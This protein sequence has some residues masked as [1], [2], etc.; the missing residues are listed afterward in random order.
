MGRAVEG[1]RG[2]RGGSVV[3]AG[4]APDIDRKA[5][6]HALWDGIADRFDPDY[7]AAEEHWDWYQENI[8]KPIAALLCHVYGHE[9]VQDQCGIPEH[10]HCVWCMTLMPNAASR[11]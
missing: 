2:G 3:K 11:D 8:E 1:K 5:L 10:D 7:E 4:S 6:M 9:P